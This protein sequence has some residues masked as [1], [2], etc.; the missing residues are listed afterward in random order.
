MQAHEDPMK[1]V[2]REAM[3]EL[4]VEIE[5]LNLIGVYSVDRGDGAS[6][7]GFAFRA[8]IV[9]GVIRLDLEEIS[10]ARFFT[11]PEIQEL[12]SRG[13]LYKPEYNI[14]T[15]G[16]YWLGRSYSLDLIRPISGR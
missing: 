8:R 7:V 6:G 10:A 3:E 11:R 14:E 12:I 15:I 2:H 16:D 9:R 4:G 5:L 1:C 13:E